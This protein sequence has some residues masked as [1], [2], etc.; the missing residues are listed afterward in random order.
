MLIAQSFK[1]PIDNSGRVIFEVD[2]DFNTRDTK[3]NHFIHRILTQ[4]IPMFTDKIITIRVSN[5]AN[6][7][8]FKKSSG[9]ILM[10]IG[11]ICDSKYCK[12]IQIA[13]L[14]IGCFRQGAKFHYER[15]FV[16]RLC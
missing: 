2:N 7:A 8:T 5:G 1:N 4:I 9:G 3:T 10:L 15:V 13:D 16:K 14:L 11:R 6:M 12:S